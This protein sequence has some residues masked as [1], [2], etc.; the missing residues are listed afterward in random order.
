MKRLNIILS[1]LLLLLLATFTACEKEQDMVKVT[2]LD[3]LEA[4]ILAPHD[5]IVVTKTSG[6]STTTFKWL[7]KTNFGVPTEIEYLLYA[8]VGDEKPTLLA[9]SLDD[10]LNIKFRDLNNKV[11]AAGA[12]FD[13]LTT[14][15]FTL[16]ASINENYAVFSQPVDVNITPTFLYPDNLYMIGAE[17]GNWNWGRDSVVTMT[18]VHSHDGQFWCVR[19]FHAGQGFK[20]CSV[21]DWKGA[22]FT[23]GTDVGFT[24]KDENAFVAADGFYSVYIDYSTETITIEPAQVYGI[25]DCFGSWDAGKYPVQVNNQTMKLT[26]SAAGELRI[27]AAS[28][29]APTDVQWWQM[30]FVILDGKIAYRGTGGDQTRVPLVAGKT[31]TLDFNAGTGSIE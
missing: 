29:G 11:V 23:L 24:T 8:Q 30:E 15:R 26:T 21:K 31:V 28:S 14:V 4:P 18:P 5:A 3:Q 20:W 7:P 9:S 6:D 17:F 13:V 10:S 1:V 2:P 16:A 27:H 12:A 22:F 19:Y 25:G